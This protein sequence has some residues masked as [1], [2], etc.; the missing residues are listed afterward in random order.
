[1]TI[2]QLASLSLLV[3]NLVTFVTYGIDKG[4]ARNEAY[5]ISEKTLL[6]MAYFFGG[7]GAWSGGSFFHHKTR[8]WYFKM[9][10]IV[11][12]TIDLIAIYFIWR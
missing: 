2:Q 4:K 6:F 12:I 1:M 9:A 3:W 7:V 10:W 11:G 8:K 5:R